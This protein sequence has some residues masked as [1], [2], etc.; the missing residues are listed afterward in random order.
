MKAQLITADNKL[1]EKAKENF[2]VVHIKDYV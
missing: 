1:Y 2:D